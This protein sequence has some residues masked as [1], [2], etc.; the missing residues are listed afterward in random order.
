MRGVSAVNYINEKQLLLNA[1]LENTQAQTDAIEDH[2]IEVLEALITQR[3]G[4]MK[5][6]DEL[7]Q[8]ADAI[9]PEMSKELTG[10]IKDLLAQII[11]IDNA[12]QS[13]MK[14]GLRDVKEELRKIRIGK[15]QGE[16]YGPEYGSYKEEGIFFDTKK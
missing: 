16:N 14:Q 10:P 8:K 4:I 5:Q 13:L 15:Q 2:K 7:D 11:T 6:V 1:M 12:N 3:E 9:T